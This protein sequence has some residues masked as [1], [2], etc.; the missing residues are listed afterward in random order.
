MKGKLFPLFQTDTW[1]KILE[2]KH[3][4]H[5][6]ILR[7]N[8]TYRT[9][10]KR[11]NFSSS[12]S[13]KRKLCVVGSPDNS[14]Y[15]LDGRNADLSHWMEEEKGHKRH[16]YRTS[17]GHLRITGGICE[18]RVRTMWKSGLCGLKCLNTI[19]SRHSSFSRSSLKLPGLQWMST[20]SSVDL[21]ES[22]FMCDSPQSWRHFL[23]SII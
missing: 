5:L 12:A 4:P 1:C 23:A 7:V 15:T 13:N 20:S 3:T 19:W 14:T 9:I 16:S 6:L 10:L 2:S 17:D 18:G 8:S 11:V 21:W 22:V